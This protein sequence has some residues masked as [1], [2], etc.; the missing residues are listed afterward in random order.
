MYSL[1]NRTRETSDESSELSIS[2]RVG[3]SRSLENFGLV[4]ESNSSVFTSRRKTS[5]VPA[6]KN[7]ISIHVK[8]GNENS[9]PKTSSKSELSS[10]RQKLLDRVVGLDEKLALDLAVPHAD[11]KKMTCGKCHKLLGSKFTLASH[12]QAVHGEKCH[13]CQFCGKLFARKD[14]HSL[15]V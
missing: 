1:R 2:S 8:T 11:G 4:A 3:R 14:Y 9:K 5:R 12:A 10:S 13:K 15:H 6:T 7:E